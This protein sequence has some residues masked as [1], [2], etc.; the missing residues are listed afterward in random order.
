MVTDS[1]RYDTAPRFK[2]ELASGDTRH[3]G[4]RGGLCENEWNHG[5][6]S[7]MMTIV[8]AL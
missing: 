4:G 6:T 3:S 7:P 8:F 2:G 1:I 5:K